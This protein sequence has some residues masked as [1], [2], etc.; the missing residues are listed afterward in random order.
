MK[1]KT[2]VITA[3]V[4]G[5]AAA[6]IW[7]GLQHTIKKNQKPVGVVQVGAVNYAQYMYD[8]G[9]TMYGEIVSRNVQTVELDDEY[10]LVK[11]YVETGDK[12]K[13]GDPLL[14]Y[15]MTLVELQKEMEELSKQLS[16]INLASEQKVL[17]KLQ[18][19]QIDDA[20]L[21]GEDGDFTGSAEVDIFGELVDDEVVDTATLSAD[22]LFGGENVFEDGEESTEALLSQLAVSSMLAASP[23]EG[24]GDPAVGAASPEPVDAA[25]NGDQQEQE[26][27]VNPEETA[28]Q[29]GT[30]ESSGEAEELI[31]GEDPASGD[32]G[33]DIFTDAS[34]DPVS[35]ESVFFEGGEVIDPIEGETEV[36]PETEPSEGV[37]DPDV[38]SEYI[39]YVSDFL[40]RYQFVAADF[41]AG[42]IGT[43]SQTDIDKGLEIFRTYLGEPR[44]VQ[45]E[46]DLYG[47]Q[48]L[49]ILYKVPKI[50][51]EILGSGT[52][53]EIQ[54]A[55]ENLCA[56]KFQHELYKLDPE[57]LNAKEVSNLPVSTLLALE[58]QIRNTVEAYYAVSLEKRAEYNAAGVKDVL[59][60]YV[61][62]LDNY[63]RFT[64]EDGDEEILPETEWE[65]FPWDVDA[66]LEYEPQRGYTA[67]EL[68]EAIEGQKRA[69]RATELEIRESELKIKQ[70]ERKLDS[71]IVKSTMDGVVSAAG[72]VD[73]T[74]AEEQFIVITGA[75]G[76]YVKSLISESKLEDVKIG[77]RLSGYSYEYG[78]TFTAEIT[79][80][81]VYPSDNKDDYFYF[82]EGSG[83]GSAYPF[84]AFIEADEA[85]GLGE[86]EVEMT[87]QNTSASGGIYLENYFVRREPSGR[88]YVFKRGDDG[89]LTKQYVQTGS[90]MYGQAIEIRK[91]LTE[92]DYIAFPYGKNVV[93]GAETQETDDVSGGGSYYY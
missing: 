93:E 29:E 92:D 3:A 27:I 67:A 84:Y 49:I 65:E 71:R 18:N 48:R 23:G 31:P 17:T 11:V 14:E 59:D 66:G 58:E 45:M 47:N 13:R 26:Q 36:F 24:T 64:I 88:S 10:E 56:Y 90:S 9:E 2:V 35:D 1:V 6:G 87:L 72:T 42:G 78:Q 89:M 81:S 43:V 77:D 12:V 82:D 62:A 80:I 76:L 91:G 20:G 79:E 50:V 40:A 74:V 38:L 46:E 34:D 33:E 83:A 19:G 61:T 39:G 15:D 70:Y 16:E 86:G 73:D 41:A 85:S 28:A 63:Y 60:A 32:E 25:E 57:S 5:G 30:G 51:E 75:A 69:I 52:A 21:Y 68:K 55:Y 4:L 7:F 53:Q 8:S 54:K 22:D 44:D 37:I